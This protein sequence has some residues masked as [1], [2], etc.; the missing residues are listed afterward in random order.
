MDI[1]PFQ[2]ID[3]LTISFPHIQGSFGHR[4][5][6]TLFLSSNTAARIHT[7]PTTNNSISVNLQAFTFTDGA[8][9]IWWWQLGAYKRAKNTCART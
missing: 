5:D 2:Q 7:I 3:L 6:S 8:I 9:F 4:T 1:S